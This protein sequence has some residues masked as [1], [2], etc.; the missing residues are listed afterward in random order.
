MKINLIENL[1]A[2]KITLETPGLLLHNVS[3]QSILH[4]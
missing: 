2:M 1:R 3:I 4:N